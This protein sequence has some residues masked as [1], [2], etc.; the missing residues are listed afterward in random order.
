MRCEIRI[1]LSVIGHWRSARMMLPTAEPNADR[2]F[3][4]RQRFHARQLLAFQKLQRRAAAGGDVRDLVGDAA[5]WTAATVSPP[6]TMEVAPE[7]SATACAILRVPRANSGVSN[8]PMGPF[9]T[10]VLAREI[11]SVNSS[12]VFGPMSR[13]IWSGGIGWP[14]PTMWVTASSAILLAVTWSTGSRN[15]TLRVCASCEQ[16]FGEI[17][18]VFLD[19]RF[20]DLVP[21]RLQEGV[22]HAAADDER[23][24]LVQ[25]VLDDADLVADLGAAEDGDERLGRA[26][27]APCPGIRVPS[28]SA[29]RRR[30]SRRTS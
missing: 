29:G 9:H 23:V 14:S 6:P 15:L 13:P 10:M 22:R 5:S 11:S 21:L 7:F 3:L 26:S 19:Q 28:P 2:L 25:Q 30:T 24:D 8:T 20:A 18:L 27:A 17:E 1:G 12:M 16:L 4:V